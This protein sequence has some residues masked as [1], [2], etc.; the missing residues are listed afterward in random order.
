MQKMLKY[1]IVLCIENIACNTKRH[2]KKQWIENW[3]NGPIWWYLYVS[4][5][6]IHHMLYAQRSSSKRDTMLAALCCF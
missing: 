1:K 5:S 4:S 6:R 3:Y 2:I